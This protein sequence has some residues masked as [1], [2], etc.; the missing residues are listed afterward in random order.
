MPGRVIRSALE[1]GELPTGDELLEAFS[2]VLERE[3]ERWAGR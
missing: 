2:P 3:G 1:E